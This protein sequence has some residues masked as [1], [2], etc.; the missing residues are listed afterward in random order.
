ME[1]TLATMTLRLSAARRVF[2]KITPEGLLLSLLAGLPPAAA[3]TGCQV[4]VSSGDGEE[5]GAVTMAATGP[6]APE[7]MDGLAARLE[8]LGVQVEGRSGGEGSAG[9]PLCR[10]EDGRW[11]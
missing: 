9:E 4:S 6:G 7:V 2:K 1:Q 8:Q 10:A 5:Q 11:V 3:W